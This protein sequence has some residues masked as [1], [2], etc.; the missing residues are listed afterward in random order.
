MTRIGID[1][2]EKVKRRAAKKGKLIIDELDSI[3][4]KAV[5]IEQSE[6]GS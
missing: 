3:V 4:D 6:R 5:E 2:L 1:R